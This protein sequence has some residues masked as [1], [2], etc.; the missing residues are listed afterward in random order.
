MTIFFIPILLLA[1]QFIG[2][3]TNGP[4]INWW[5]GIVI[6]A[7][8]L[9]TFL[10]Q[11]LPFTLM[12]KWSATKR[13]YGLYI[14]VSAI[15]FALLHCYSLQYVIIV[16]PAG[17]VLSYVYLFYSKNPR[18]AF[19]STTLIHALKNSVAVLSMVFEG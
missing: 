13:K 5:F 6:V 17:L 8:I 7:P 10:N 15:A 16:I 11:K 3:N 19:W 4:E 9:E 2:E 12:Q 14:W 1:D 18:I